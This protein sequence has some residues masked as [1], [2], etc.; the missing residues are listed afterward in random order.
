MLPWQGSREQFSTKKSFVAA[1]F[2]SL[3]KTQRLALLADAD[4]QIE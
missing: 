4:I 3:C 1:S 2:F